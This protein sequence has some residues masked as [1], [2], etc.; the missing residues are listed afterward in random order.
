MSLT[1]EIW[2]ED[3]AD[4]EPEFVTA[5]HPCRTC[6]GELSHSQIR[7]R[8][9]VCSACISAR[10]RVSEDQAKPA[11]PRVRAP[12]GEGSRV[13]LNCWPVEFGVIERKGLLRGWWVTT[14]YGTHLYADADVRTA[15]GET[16]TLP[17]VV[18]EERA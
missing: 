15:T 3:R 10:R 6:G 8:E 13:R 1:E 18:M 12:L 5:L 11:K 4:R 9:R 2:A 17:A 16:V 14:D 7:R